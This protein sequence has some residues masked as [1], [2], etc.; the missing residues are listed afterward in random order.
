MRRKPWIGVRWCDWLMSLKNSDKVV[1]LPGGASNV[2]TALGPRLFVVATVSLMLVPGCVRPA[3]DGHP[4]DVPAPPSW[5]EGQWWKYQGSNGIKYTYRV[6]G[7]DHRWGNASYRV[8]VELDRPDESGASFWIQWLDVKTLGHVAMREGTMD[9]DSSCPVSP[10]FPLERAEK[11]NCQVRWSHGGQTM[12]EYWE[13][14]SKRPQGWQQL[15]FPWGKDWAYLV[16]IESRSPYSTG[17]AS[18]IWYSPRV[19]YYVRTDILDGMNR[20]LLSW[21]LS[22][23]NS[24]PGA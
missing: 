19:N 6:E 10:I 12:Y 1:A 8:R 22:H 13:N 9:V 16:E 2:L 17:V 21:G 14:S 20:T 4:R 7:V 15:E 24:G 18:S 23:S 11:T 3:G 5:S